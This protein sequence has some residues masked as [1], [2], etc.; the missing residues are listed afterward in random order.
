MWK[1]SKQAGLGWGSL[2]PCP[3]MGLNCHSIWICNELRKPG[4]LRLGRGLSD[5]VLSFKFS[6][7]LSYL[8]L[9]VLLPVTLSSN[10][11]NPILINNLLFTWL[12]NVINVYG[13]LYEKSLL[14]PWFDRRWIKVKRIWPMVVGS[15]SWRPRSSYRGVAKTSL[16]ITIVRILSRWVM[17]VIR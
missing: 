17:L 11:P 14:L 13:L 3:Q 2:K 15:S 7:R 8:C 1:R 6:P 10:E 9:L 4:Q 16:K 12:L 5:A